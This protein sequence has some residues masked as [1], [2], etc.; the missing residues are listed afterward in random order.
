[1]N[2]LTFTTNSTS[3][4]LGVGY[5]VNEKV[6]V[7][8]GYFKTFYDTYNKVSQNYNNVANIIG[9]AEGADRALQLVESGA[10]KGSDTFTRTNQVFGLGVEL[11]F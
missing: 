11:T 5:Q 3:L 9:L 2:D 1:M 6:K 4:G 10:V 7:H 8:A